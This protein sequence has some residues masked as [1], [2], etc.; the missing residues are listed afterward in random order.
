MGADGRHPLRRVA[1][2][3]SES[4]RSLL[5]QHFCSNDLGNLQNADDRNMGQGNKRV[6]EGSRDTQ[7]NTAT[8]DDGEKARAN[9]DDFCLDCMGHATADQRRAN[10]DCEWGP[11]AP[12]FLRGSLMGIIQEFRESTALKQTR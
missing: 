2:L 12:T 10:G 7:G 6:W 4:S 5:E 8:L 11:I 3:G 1:C 9:D